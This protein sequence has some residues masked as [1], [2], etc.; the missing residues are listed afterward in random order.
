ME[1]TEEIEATLKQL[2]ET[3]LRYVHYTFD[4]TVK[5][6]DT[7]SIVERIKQIEKQIYL[8]I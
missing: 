5:F 1:K 3:V 6:D 7:I 8:L 4:E 2:E